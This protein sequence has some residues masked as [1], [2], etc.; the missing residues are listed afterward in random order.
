M[1]SSTRELTKEFMQAISLHGLNTHD[2]V[3]IL[4][5]LQS[6]S[7]DAAP[8]IGPDGQTL[9]NIKDHFANTIIVDDINGFDNTLVT[10]FKERV[11]AN[12]I[13]VDELNLVFRK[14]LKTTN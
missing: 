13:S 2:F 3:Y 5:W 10:P 14:I 1:F 4:P 6:E 11:E 9:Q 12:G 7:K 8:W